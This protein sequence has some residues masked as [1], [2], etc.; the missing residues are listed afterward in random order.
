MA[1]AFSYRKGLN[2]VHTEA[3]RVLIS[4]AGQI[5]RWRV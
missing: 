1:G 3:R 5:A 2:P 4:G